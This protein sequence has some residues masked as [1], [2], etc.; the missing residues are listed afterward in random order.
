[1]AIN[2]MQHVLGSS[3]SL[4][5]HGRAG[6][7]ATI[8]SFLYSVPPS[9]RKKFWPSSP[10]LKLWRADIQAGE[11][12]G[13]LSVIPTR[14]FCPPSFSDSDFSAAEFRIS[15]PPAIACAKQWRAGCEMRRLF[16]ILDFWCSIEVIESKYH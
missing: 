5:A 14:N 1:M 13:G 10:S 3:L 15:L 7:R 11:K 2:F 12:E 8:F 4:P 9:A 6:A 16:T